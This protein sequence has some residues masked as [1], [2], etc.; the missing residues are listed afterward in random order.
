M[1]SQRMM[2]TSQASKKCCIKASQSAATRRL[3]FSFCILHGT[4]PRQSSRTAGVKLLDH[5][6]SEDPERTSGGHIARGR[7]PCPRR[8]RRPLMSFRLPRAKRAPV[9][10]PKTP[11]RGRD[12]RGRRSRRGYALRRLAITD[13][14]T[15]QS[16]IHRAL[17]ENMCGA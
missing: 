15:E 4:R 13:V 8:D 3:S 1:L 2:G 6:Q 12:I 17:S 7:T 11:A 10:A 5:S 16:P 14:L 9:A